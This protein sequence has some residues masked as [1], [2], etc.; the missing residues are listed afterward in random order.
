MLGPTLYQAFK[1]VKATFDPDNILNPGKIINTPPMTENLRL[2][3]S[4]E[5]KEPET[6]LDFSKDGGFSRAVE[7]CNGVGEC[8]KHLTGTMCPSYM[9]TREEKHSTRG[10]ANAL[11][12]VL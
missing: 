4:Y 8:R 7:M 5:S 1:D 10:R 6:L 3:P 11:R 12:S 9:A 2:S